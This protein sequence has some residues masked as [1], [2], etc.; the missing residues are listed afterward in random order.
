ML[1]SCAVTE[2]HCTNAVYKKRI[3]SAKHTAP[4]N[5]H[6]N[7]IPTNASQTRSINHVV[8]HPSTIAATCALAVPR[9][10]AGSR[11]LRR[12]LSSIRNYSSP[13][14][15]NL[16]PALPPST[17]PRLPRRSPRPL[18]CPQ[19]SRWPRPTVISPRGVREV[20]ARTLWSLWTRRPSTHG[21]CDGQACRA[22]PKPRTRQQRWRSLPLRVSITAPSPLHPLAESRSLG[23]S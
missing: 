16:S 1:V 9:P 4:S 6:R 23:I 13:D 14:H 2:V 22:A 8:R 7:L 5:Y 12:L 19:R 18:R 20:P 21:S 10:N 15:A 17:R 11:W 3:F